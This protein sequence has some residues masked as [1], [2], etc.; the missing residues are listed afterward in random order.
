MSRISKALLVVCLASLW[1]SA[2]AGAFE[3]E[4]DLANDLA[5]LDADPTM[6]YVLMNYGSGFALAVGSISSGT[7]DTVQTTEFYTND[8]T[9]DYGYGGTHSWQEWSNAYTTWMLG[10]HPCQTFIACI[11]SGSSV[12]Q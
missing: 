6:G 1:F 2:S 5:A 9:F 10:L 3:D 8:G 4:S 12:V 7:F 11:Q